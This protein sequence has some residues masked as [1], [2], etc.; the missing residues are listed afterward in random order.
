MFILA[1]TK[2][3]LKKKGES[4]EN[5]HCTHCG[6]DGKF[7]YSVS[8][9]Y[10]TVFFVPIAPLPFSK[11]EYFH[12]PKCTYGIKLTK[13]NREE[14]MNKLN[15][16]NS[17]IE[18]KP[19][20]SSVVQS[21]NTD[22]KETDSITYK[23]PQN[24]A[25]STVHGDSAVRTAENYNR[26]GLDYFNQSKYELA[27]DRF[28]KAMTADPNDPVYVFNV[29]EVFRCKNDFDNARLFYERSGYMGYADGY[30]RIAYLYMPGTF[31]SWT[32]Q[33]VNDP[34]LAIYW[35]NRSIESLSE[36]DTARIAPRLNNIGI[37]YDRL[38]QPVKAAAY[39]WLAAKLGNSSSS[40]DYNLFKTKVETSKLVQIEQIS[41][42]AHLRNFIQNQ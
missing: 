4:K 22:N 5:F 7:H 35:F 31:A 26:E 13:E 32:I 24:S 27:Y 38:N 34:N 21:K 28:M 40:E 29:G 8:R 16:N 18:E 9:S 20:A 39:M 12:C 37:C 42:L 33:R 15:M 19:N 30:S 1:G 10:S 3:K 41:T 36:N 23:M 17:S 2:N 14:Y 25:A 6:Y 11:E